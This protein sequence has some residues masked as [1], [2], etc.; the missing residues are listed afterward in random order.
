MRVTLV[1]ETYPP[2]V[3]G[4]A[5]TLDRLV[6]YLRRCGDEVQLLVPRFPAG[7][8]GIERDVTVTQFRS[9]PLPLY[10]QVRIGLALPSEIVGAL[11]AFSPDVVHVATE[12]PLG[13]A[14]L[15]ACRRLDIPLVTSYHTH[16]PNY[17]RWYRLGLLE[18][19]AWRYLRS[20]HNAGRRTLCPTAT[21]QNILQEKGFNDLAVWPRGVDTELFDPAKR[22]AHV[23][24]EAG[25]L[26]DGYLLLYVGRLAVEKNLSALL[27]AYAHLPYRGRARLML[28]GDGPC[29][30]RLERQAP[31]GVVFAGFRRGEELAQAYAAADLFVFPSLTDTF[32]N[33]MLEAMA[34]GV[35]VVGFDVPGPRDVV[36]RGRTG[37]LAIPVCP[38][39][40]AESIRAAL[41][42]PKGLRHMSDAARQ[43]AL[44]RHWDAVGAGVRETYADVVQTSPS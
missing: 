42:D 29:R 28:V 6:R 30:A 35:P 12:G 10:P 39:A 36:Q 31:V 4:V 3:N 13:L 15:R 27:Q 34:S 8:N 23:R 21:V 11:N 37:L 5:R 43:H 1:T 25:V 20:F 41:D 7:R 18:P 32:G 40:L 19:I 24:A 22:S 2:E 14:A 9:I 17:L 16:F 38:K 33:V 44:T 26:R